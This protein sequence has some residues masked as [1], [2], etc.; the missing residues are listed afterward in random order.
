M[1]Y[2]LY[3]REFVSYS[4]EQRVLLTT[5]HLLIPPCVTQIPPKFVLHPKGSF[6]DRIIISSVHDDTFGLVGFV[7][8]KRP[9]ESQ[10]SCNTSS[11]P[12]QVTR[13]LSKLSTCSKSCPS[14]LLPPGPA[15]CPTPRDPKRSVFSPPLRSPRVPS[16]LQCLNL[17][18]TK[19]QFRTWRE[20]SWFLLL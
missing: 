2:F 3:L 8:T 13:S 1:L 15:R 17:Q 11:L 7:L 20:D 18:W 6:V 5:H 10:A 9:K 19:H 4:D 16:F 12:N 14:H